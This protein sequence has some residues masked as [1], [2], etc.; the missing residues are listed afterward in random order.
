MFIVL[1]LPAC[2]WFAPFA[3]DVYI[4]KKNIIVSI[5]AITATSQQASSVPY[6]CLG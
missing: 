5:I 2:K 4:N 6:P 3:V 1:I